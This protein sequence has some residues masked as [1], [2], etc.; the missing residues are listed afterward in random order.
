MQPHSKNSYQG[1]KL[2]VTK[3]ISSQ[4]KPSVSQRVPHYLY[5]AQRQKSSENPFI[6]NQIGSLYEK[7]R[8]QKQETKN[9]FQPDRYSHTLKNKN[10]Y[11]FQSVTN[12]K[13]A[14]NLN[15]FKTSLGFKDEY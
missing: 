11:Q 9:D 8:N 1:K 4:Q 12:P 3:I 15:I 14:R 7:Y 6:T 13:N 5:E 2:V 10:P